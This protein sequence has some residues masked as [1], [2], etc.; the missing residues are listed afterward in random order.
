M[1]R[2]PINFFLEDVSFNLYHKNAVRTWILQ[3]IDKE[4]H[5]LKELNF[6]F[7]SDDYLLSIN[8]N[9][10]QHTTLTDIITFDTREE[11]EIRDNKGK[12][13]SLDRHIQGEIY[14]SYQRVRENAGIF[15]MTLKDELHRVI[16]HGVLHLLGYK[17]KNAAD[18]GRMTE[19]E[20]YYLSVRAF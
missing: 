12:K 11:K 9:Y 2:I 16:I 5:T 8:K 10:L 4:G 3:V 17:D 6:I 1:K 19:K 7:C 20:D 18:K 15:K 14:I 13:N